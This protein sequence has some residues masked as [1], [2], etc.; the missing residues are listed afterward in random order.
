MINGFCSVKQP[1]ISFSRFV[2]SD[3]EEM[4]VYSAKFANSLRSKYQAPKPSVGKSG[5]GDRPEVT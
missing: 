5:G 2:G 3:F 4:L 1:G